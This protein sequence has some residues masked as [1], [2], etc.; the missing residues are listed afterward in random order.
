MPKLMAFWQLRDGPFRHKML[1]SPH[2]LI[3]L[4]ISSAEVL[5]NMINQLP[6]TFEP[7]S[8]AARFAVAC[9]LKPT[10]LFLLK[11]SEV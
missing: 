6:T 5:Q 9:F 4:A 3:F 1:F 2:M 10:A 8:I 7:A 11:A